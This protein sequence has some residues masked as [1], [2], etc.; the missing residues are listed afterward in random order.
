[1]F[2]DLCAIL[3]RATDGPIPFV[4]QLATAPWHFDD[5]Y[6]S[7]LVVGINVRITFLQEA[8]T[9]SRMGSR[10]KERSLLYIT[11]PRIVHFSP[12]RGP[13][14]LEWMPSYSRPGSRGCV[15]THKYSGYC[16]E[17]PLYQRKLQLCIRYKSWRHKYT[18]WETS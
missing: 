17:S 7:H 12:F 11:P 2:E 6:I 18:P 16:V 10:L 9:W 8:H 4:N 14:G 1:M 5:R 3:S 13:I 15:K